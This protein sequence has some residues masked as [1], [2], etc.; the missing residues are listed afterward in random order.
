MFLEGLVPVVVPAFPVAYGVVVLVMPLGLD[1]SVE[2]ERGPV[3]VLFPFFIVAGA[4]KVA[5]V[6]PLLELAVR[7]IVLERDFQLLDAVRVPFDLLE[8]FAIRIDP[9]RGFL[10][11]VHVVVQ[12]FFFGPFYGTSAKE[13]NN[14]KK[15][16]CFDGIHIR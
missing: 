5:E 11:V 4:D 8:N 2:I 10:D 12:H 14:A 7:D 13:R 15:G 9:D 1:F 3:A 16:D 6:A